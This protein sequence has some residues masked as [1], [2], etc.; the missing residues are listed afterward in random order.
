[1]IFSTPFPPEEG[2]GNYVTG[3]AKELVKGG[4][5]VVGVT[6]GSPFQISEGNFEGLRVIEAPFIKVYP[7]HIQIHSLSIQKIVRKLENSVDIFHVHSPLCPV[8]KS[9]RPIVST[10]H[11]MMMNEIRHLDSWGLR[12]IEARAQTILFARKLEQRLLD[13]SRIVSVV[14]EEVKQSLSSYQ[15]DLSK[16]RV[17]HNGV[18]CSR[19]TPGGADRIPGLLLFVGRIDLRKGV[20][21]LLEAFSRIESKELTLQI[22]GKGPLFGMVER[23]IR[24][25]KLGDRV[26]LRGHIPMD[27]LI[28]LYQTAELFILPSRYEGLPTV[29]LEAMACGA[30]CVSADVGG[31][32]ELIRDGVDGALVPRASPDALAECIWQLHENPGK[33]EELGSNARLRVVSSFSWPITASKHLTMYDMAT[34]D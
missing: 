17:V 5:E 2:I 25:M 7:I 34:S 12:E 3:L 13:A 6:R 15:V 8:P 30:A 29:L 33:R 31:V 28:E 14:S 19:F 4:H 1:M 11:T 10:F 9:S 20:F 16:V 27:D 26:L 18:D 24:E 32:S 21:D 22:V 23:R